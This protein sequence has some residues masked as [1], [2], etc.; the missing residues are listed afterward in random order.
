MVIA[1]R[2]VHS[3]LEKVP[4]ENGRG[5]KPHVYISGKDELAEEA[6]RLEE[7]GPLVHVDLVDGLDVVPTGD[8]VDLNFSSSSSRSTP[9]YRKRAYPKGYSKQAVVQA[10]ELQKLQGM[11]LLNV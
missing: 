4:I 8:L 1:L 11:Y 3:L 6:Q 9:I 7:G 10:V 5:F 2:S